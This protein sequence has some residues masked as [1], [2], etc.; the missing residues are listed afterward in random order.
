MMT[1]RL[2]KQRINKYEWC[3]KFITKTG[4]ATP[5]SGALAVGVMIL[6]KLGNIYMPVKIS[7]VIVGGVYA[8]TNNQERR[9]TKIADGNV[10]YESRGGNVKNDWAPGHTLASPPSIEDFSDACDKVISS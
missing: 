8:T 3:T 7:E 6:V 2:W 10:F 9:V 1:K 4:N 5:K